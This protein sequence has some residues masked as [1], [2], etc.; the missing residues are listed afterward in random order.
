MMRS[1]ALGHQALA[2]NDYAAA[3]AAI[4]EGIEAIRQ[5]LRDY[6][7]TD[8]E[9]ECM[10]L[11]FL[12]RWRREVEAERPLGPVERLEPQLTQRLPSRITRKPRA[13]AT[14]CA[15]CVASR[16]P[17]LPR[18]IEVP[19]PQAGNDHERPCRPARSGLR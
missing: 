10:E 16:S 12:L 4:D 7:K 11:G 17:V 9:A 8:S 19:R 14:S 18:V 5:F 6:N 15:G 2:K 13:F 1:R 3:L